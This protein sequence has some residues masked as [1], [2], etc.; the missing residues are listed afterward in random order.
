MNLSSISSLI[1]VSLGM[2]SWFVTDRH[3]GFSDICLQ[4]ITHA[5][6]HPGALNCCTAAYNI[7]LTC[8]YLYIFFHLL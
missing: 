7:S 8:T 1:C 4:V 5:E 3:F 2:C 6:L